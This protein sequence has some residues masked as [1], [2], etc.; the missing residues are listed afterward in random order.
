[1]FITV[2]TAARLLSLS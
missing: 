2:F 1:M